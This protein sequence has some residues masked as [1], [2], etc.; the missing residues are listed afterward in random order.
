[1]GFLSNPEESQL[2]RSEIY[3]KKI[4]ASIYQGVLKY[5]SGEKVGTP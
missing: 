2:L 4:A 1:V 5:Y 3:Q